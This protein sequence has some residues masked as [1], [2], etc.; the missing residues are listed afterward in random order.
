M[1]A[2]EV[3]IATL[4]VLDLAPGADRRSSN[5]E[6]GRSGRKKGEKHGCTLPSGA[7]A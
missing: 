1:V 6:A 2:S 4:H 3:A 5:L 7:I